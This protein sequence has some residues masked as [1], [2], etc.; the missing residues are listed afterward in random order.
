MDNP[1]RPEERLCFNV[2]PV[3]RRD[4]GTLP[5]TLHDLLAVGS[6]HSRLVVRT[7]FAVFLVILVVVWM[8][9]GQYESEM[10]ILVKQERVDP[11]VS[12]DESSRNQ[13]SQAVSEAQLNSEVELLKSRDLLA[14]VVVATGLPERNKTGSATRLWTLLTSRVE[15]EVLASRLE[16]GFAYQELRVAQAVHDAARELNVQPLRKSNVIRVTYSSPDPNLSAT[17]LKTLADRYLEKHLAVHRPAGAFDFFDQQAEQYRKNLVNLESRL[18]QYDREQGVVSGQTEKE[19]ALR[20]LADVEASERSTRA[21]IAETEQRVRAL[22]AETAAT[23]ARTTTDV[24]S[25]SVRLIEQFQASLTTLE[26]K[27]IELS[28]QFKPDYPPLQAV[29]SQ[30]AELQASIAAAAESPV[31]EETTGRDPTF[32]FLQTELAKNRAELAALRARAG[33]LG[34]TAAAHKAN[35]LRLE[36]I[37][38]VERDLSREAKQAEQNYLLHAQKR[39]ETRVSNA[40][41]VRRIVN[42]AVAEEPTVPIEP[43]GLPRSL[44]VMLGAMLAGISSV[45]LAFVADYRDRPSRTPDEE[46]RAARQSRP[47]EPPHH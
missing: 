11:V 31:R 3:T 36:R 20:Q 33:A 40:L 9:P 27:R 2:R 24:R 18:A 34:A 41:D 47:G 44:L 15:K 42:V 8:Q 7:F 1:T 26:L 23:P 30:I 38:L 28:Q 19:T 29:Q 21:Q 25:G 17:V 43:S 13:T 4:G 35:A 10:K 22:E 12:S 32:T 5:L 39:E 37:D 14:K 16:K 46:S 45:G 6:A